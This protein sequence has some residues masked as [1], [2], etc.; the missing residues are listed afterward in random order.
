MHNFS[1]HLMIVDVESVQIVA[2]NFHLPSLALQEDVARANAGVFYYDVVIFSRPDCKGRL[3][4]KRE[5]LVAVSHHNL[6]TCHFSQM[7][8]T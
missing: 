3:V 5:V 8:L 1:V 4:R 2:S 6:D 7:I